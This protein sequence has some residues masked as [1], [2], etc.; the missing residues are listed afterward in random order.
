MK[1]DLRS[2]RS[3]VEV[4]LGLAVFAI[5]RQSLG[6]DWFVAVIAILVITAASLE[7]LSGFT[8]WR[9]DDTPNRGRDTPQWP[10]RSGALRLWTGGYCLAL[11]LLLT[12]LPLLL[13][14]VW[15]LLIAAACVTL[16]LILTIFFLPLQ[17]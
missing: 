17:E 7:C 13:H 5:S 2:L 15:F 12:V 1:V 6:L 16:I 14:V 9:R 3:A 10:R 4:P 8:L 11:A